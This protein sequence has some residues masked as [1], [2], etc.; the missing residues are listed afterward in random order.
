MLHDLAQDG[1]DNAIKGAR[2][3]LSLLAFN[4]LDHQVMVDRNGAASSSV[5]MLTDTPYRT[6][7]T[8]TKYIQSHNGAPCLTTSSRHVQC[9][10]IAKCQK[11]LSAPERIQAD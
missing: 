3:H 7:V 11:W 8:W 5:F 6:L 1:P 2:G 10:M 9:D 4:K